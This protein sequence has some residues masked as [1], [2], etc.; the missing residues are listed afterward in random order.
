[1]IWKLLFRVTAVATTLVIAPFLLDKRAQDVLGGWL[2]FLPALAVIVV[3]IGIAALPKEFSLLNR[4][5]D[6]YQESQNAAFRGLAGW[7]D[8]DIGPQKWW[9]TWSFRVYAFLTLVLIGAL[10]V[11]VMF[12]INWKEAIKK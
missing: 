12:L 3:L 7:T 4:V 9:K 6:T 8:H 2:A 11:F 10:S 5:K 1:M